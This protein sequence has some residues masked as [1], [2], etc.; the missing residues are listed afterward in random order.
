M[1]L[2]FISC[3]K[4]DDTVELSTAPTIISIW[5]DNGPEMTIVTI[6]GKNFSSIPNENQ[7]QFNGVDAIV[8][9]AD[10]KH[11]K[12]YRQ[13]GRAMGKVTITVQEQMAE[14]PVYTCETPLPS[15]YLVSTYAAGSGSGRFAERTRY[16]CPIQKPRS[17]AIDAQGNLIVADRQNHTI[18]KIS[19][20]GDVTTIAGDGTAGFADGPAVTAKFSSPWKRGDR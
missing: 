19:T 6:N 14:G 9:E 2:L 18:R 5:P 4:D 1:G 15:E 13:K 12:W 17:V 11:C 7:V 10:Q 8:I 3:K 20:A 16:R